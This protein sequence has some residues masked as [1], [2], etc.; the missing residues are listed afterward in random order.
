MLWSSWALHDWQ[1]DRWCAVKMQESWWHA[2]AWHWDPITSF[3]YDFSRNYAYCE[4]MVTKRKVLS[5]SAYCISAAQ[6]M[7]K[8][9]M[10]SNVFGEALLPCGYLAAMHSKS[11]RKL[12]SFFG[13]CF[14]SEQ[15][16]MLVVFPGSCKLQPKETLSSFY[17]TKGQ[18]W[19][20]TVSSKSR[21]VLL[22]TKTRCAFMCNLVWV[23]SSSLYYVNMKQQSFQTFRTPSSG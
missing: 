9:R 3:R 10:I 8:L 5:T 2:I 7:G 6:T 11:H 17:E 18:L 20:C 13:I 1:D 21:I 4:K 23:P 19:M 15:S 14:D 12:T 16:H 22:W